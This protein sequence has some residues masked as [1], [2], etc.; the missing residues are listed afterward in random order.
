[1]IIKGPK[2]PY[3]AYFVL[4]I[5]LSDS[6]IVKHTDMY[7]YSISHSLNSLT[8]SGSYYFYLSNF[9]IYL[10]SKLTYKLIFN[11]NELIN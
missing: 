1:M 2:D 10:I 9:F 11:L 7:V 3:I 6:Y 5:I 4:L 8:I